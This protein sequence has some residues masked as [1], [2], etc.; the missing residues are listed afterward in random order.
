MTTATAARL[1]ISLGSPNPRLGWLGW[2]SLVTA[3]LVLAPVLAVVWNVFLPSETTWS[4]LVSTVLPNYIWNTFLL[5]LMVA[6]GV[7]SLPLASSH[8]FRVALKTAVIG[9][10]WYRPSAE[11]H[12]Q[13]R[14]ARGVARVP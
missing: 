2:V 10:H 8:R 11:F 9:T 13:Y 14:S 6:A 3:A 7:I 12:R 1:R 4:H 5:V